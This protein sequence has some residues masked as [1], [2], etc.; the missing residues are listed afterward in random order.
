MITCVQNIRIIIDFWGI[1]KQQKYNVLEQT[2]KLEIRNI[3]DT[4]GYRAVQVFIQG[5]EHIPPEPEKVPNLMMYYIYNY[6]ILIIYMI[7]INYIYIILI[8]RKTHT[9]FIMK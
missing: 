8:L 2:D 6:N 1:N 7:I 9:Q 4:E 5:S 3:K